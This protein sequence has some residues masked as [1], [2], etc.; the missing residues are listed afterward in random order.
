VRDVENR[1]REL[2]ECNKRLEAHIHVRRAGPAPHCAALHCWLPCYHHALPTPAATRARRQLLM[3]PPPPAA[4]LPRPQDL[5]SRKRAPLYQKKQEDELRAANEKAQEAEI[6]AQEAELRAKE[7]KARAGA[8]RC[9][10]CCCC[11]CRPLLLPP[12]AVAC[13]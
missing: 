2:Y 7:V 4:P 6:R 5:E 3:P 13:V 1:S 11:R 10:C 8:A 9:C 12:A